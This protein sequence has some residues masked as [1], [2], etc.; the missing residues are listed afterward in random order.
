MA[1]KTNKLVEEIKK[2]YEN[3]K[4]LRSN[5]ERNWLLNINFLV[6]NQH[7]CI[8]PSGQI[9]NQAK[10][11]YW[12]EREVFNHIAPIVETRLSKFGSLKGS[13]TVRPASSDLEDIR[14]AKFS[15]SLIKSVEENKNMS[16]LSN[17][18]T[19]WSE[20]CGT[21]FYKIC[22]SDK[23]GAIIGKKDN[24]TVYEGDIEISVCSPYEVYPDSL[25]CSTLEECASL[26]YAKAYPV[27]SIESNWG[28]KLLGRDI[29]TINMD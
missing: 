17:L 12:Q 2:D 4:E 23:K 15:T 18:A 1:T 16:K 19:F 27:D 14:T 10:D 6:G 22:W 26:I 20:V 9:E 8:M 3:R 13:V 5:V 7:S 29:S 25:A 21:A 28:V 24:D 11:F